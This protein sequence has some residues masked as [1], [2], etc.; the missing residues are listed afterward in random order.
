M[1]SSATVAPA[2]PAQAWTP[3]EHQHANLNQLDEKVDE[4]TGS[5][6]ALA[7]GYI[8]DGNGSYLDA[9]EPKLG[10]VELKFVP[11][12]IAREQLQGVNRC[13]IQAW[14]GAYMVAGAG[15]QRHQ[16]DAIETYQNC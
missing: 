2:P 12:D 7:S 11:L 9:N 14:M 6:L 16:P 3:P 4:S 10:Q 1:V 15:Y 5:R 13:Q 8:A